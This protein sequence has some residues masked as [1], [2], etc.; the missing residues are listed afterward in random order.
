MVAS[1][2]LMDNKH[3]STFFSPAAAA[4]ETVGAEK[5]DAAAERKSEQLS[6]L[7]TSATPLT[8]HL[9]GNCSLVPL[10]QQI[11]AP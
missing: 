5:V 3:C 4:A 10:V 11:S 7:P 6:T 9:S 1:G 2:L 8:P